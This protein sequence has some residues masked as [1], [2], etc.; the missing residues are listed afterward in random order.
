MTVFLAKEI[1][2][3]KLKVGILTRGYGRS[4]Q[5]T[6]I[7]C[8]DKEKEKTYI[9]LRLAMNQFFYIKNYVMS[10]LQFQKIV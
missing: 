6:I 8:N 4:S 7:I 2:K 9:H 1:L 3:K 5:N 10:R